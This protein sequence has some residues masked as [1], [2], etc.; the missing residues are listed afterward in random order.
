MA[1]VLD[2]NILCERVIDFSIIENT[3]K[4][5]SL[6]LASV[7]SIDSWVWDNEQPIKELRQISDIVDSNK[8]VIIKLK[9]PLFKDVGIYIER[10]DSCYLYTVWINTEGHPQ[11]DSDV[12][13]PE[14]REY[15]EKVYQ[16]ISVVANSELDLL[17]VV[18]IGVESDFYYSNN[19]KDIIRRSKNITVWILNSD[20][21]EEEMLINYMKKNAK[22]INKI[23]YE[24]VR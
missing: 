4:M 14:N 6:R 10:V 19:V 15:Y 12:I 8:I 20:F 23:I 3:I 5:Y 11:L 21:R 24:K 1:V 2:V 9:A 13:T 7:S 16:G 22:Y 18:G 17:K